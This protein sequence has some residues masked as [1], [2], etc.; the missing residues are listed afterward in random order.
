MSDLLVAPVQIWRKDD[1]VP[2]VGV[3]VLEDD[4]GALDLDLDRGTTQRGLQ[5]GAVGL[6]RLPVGDRRAADDVVKQDIFDRV[7]TKGFG[8]LGEDL[9]LAAIPLT[10]QGM[11]QPPERT[12][13]RQERS[14]RNVA[15]R[16][17]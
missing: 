7:D 11:S 8:Q 15:V 17:N 10:R 4:Q 14:Q 2:G 5:D 13:G 6:E 3:A 1:R 16:E 9:L 12:V